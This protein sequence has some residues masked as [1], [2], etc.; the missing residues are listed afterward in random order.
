MTIFNLMNK[1]DGI[2]CQ[3]NYKI[4]LVMC[5]EYF[6]TCCLTLLK[7]GEGMNDDPCCAA[8]CQDTRS[9]TTDDKTKDKNEN[10]LGHPPMANSMN[11]VRHPPMANSMNRVRHPPMAN[12]MNPI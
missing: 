5:I 1:I 12:P 9:S 6:L 3:Y 2:K 8:L 7:E 4:I 10:L 11:R